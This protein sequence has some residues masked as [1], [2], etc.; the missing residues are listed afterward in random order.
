MEIKV[1][2]FDNEKE[3]KVDTINGYDYQKFEYRGMQVCI[4][5]N[6]ATILGRCKKNHNVYFGSIPNFC[7]KAFLEIDYDKDNEN[8]FTEDY[9]RIKKNG[10]IELINIGSPM[11]LNSEDN[12]SIVAA[13]D[14]PTSGYNSLLAATGFSTVLCFENNVLTRICYKYRYLDSNGEINSG[15]KEVFTHL[16]FYDTDYD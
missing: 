8:F 3:F 14:L 16:D 5:K 15:R 7:I 2:Q 6:Y 4:P 11:V 10:F 12:T 13:I 1:K 9:D